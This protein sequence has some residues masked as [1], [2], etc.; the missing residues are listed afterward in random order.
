MKSQVW[1]WNTKWNK[2]PLTACFINFYFINADLKSSVIDYVAS[3]I[4][5]ISEVLMHVAQLRGY[6]KIMESWKITQK[7]KQSKF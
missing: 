1:S 5:C 6:V 3:L 7:L 4:H 2:F